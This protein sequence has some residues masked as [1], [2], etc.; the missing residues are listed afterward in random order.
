MKRSLMLGLLGT[1]LATASPALYAADCLEFDIEL[2]P[3]VPAGEVGQG[4]FELSNCG[5][6]AGTA[7]L[8]ITFEIPAGPTIVI[9]DI[10]VRLG[11]GETISREFLYP[12]PPAFV[13]YTFGVCVDATLGEAMASDCASTTII[14]SPG[15]PAAGAE[16]F[17]FAMA[18]SSECVEVDLELSDVIYTGAGDFFGEAYFELTNC[19]DEDAVI[20]L[21]LD[22]EGY[23]L[24]DVIAL[25]VRLGAGE[26]VS[27]EW[28][29]P[30]PPFIPAGSYTIC[31][32]ATSGG[33]IATD[34]ETIEVRS[35]QPVGASDQ[36][37]SGVS[38]FP[39]PFNPVTSI[40]FTLKDQLPV[41]VAVVNL[42]GQRVRTL[43]SDQAMAAGEQQVTWDGT[44]DLGRAVSS[45]IYFY[46]VEAAGQTVKEKM[47]LI[48]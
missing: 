4:Y 32:T 7:L 21:G 47:V 30:V 19:G 36:P 18:L 35:G 28:R 34:C 42:L 8:S 43:V 14:E 11:A 9:D 40:S 39:N 17:K 29:F 5:D 22:I 27:R 45:G 12:A 15:A 31:V 48:K 2:T 44:D 6:E 38:N 24:F 16:N 13:G 1:V 41:S 23:D 25:P 3:E 20:Q 26:T 46:L 33:A 37:I 10:P